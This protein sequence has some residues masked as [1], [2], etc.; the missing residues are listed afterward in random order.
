MCT[1]TSALTHTRTH[2]HAHT[3]THEWVGVDA[4]VVNVASAYDASFEIVG[5]TVI[6]A[7]VDVVATF[8][9]ATSVIDTP[10]DVVV[11]VIDVVVYVEAH[12]AS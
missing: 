3:H 4:S 5:T 1:H 2:T 11:V 7:I 9:T 8:A 12:A 10:T 6:I